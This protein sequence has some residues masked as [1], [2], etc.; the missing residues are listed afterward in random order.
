MNGYVERR[1]GPAVPRPAYEAWR[2]LARTLYSCADGHNDHAA[3]MPSSRPGLSAA[4]A[5]QWSLNPKLWYDP[6]EVRE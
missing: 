2:V 6:N 5:G 1:Y 3:D 4:E